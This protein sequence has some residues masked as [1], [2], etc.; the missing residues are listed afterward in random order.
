MA[1][2]GM[3]TFRFRSEK[4]SDFVTFPGDSVTVEILKQLI[5]DKRIRYLIR[6]TQRKRVFQEKSAFRLQHSRDAILKKDIQ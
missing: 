6:Q 1:K 5:E 2:E 3:I 4:N